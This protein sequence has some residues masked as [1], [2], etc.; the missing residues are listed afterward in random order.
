MIISA[1]RLLREAPACFIEQ[2]RGHAQ[3]S[4]GRLDVW[5]A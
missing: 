3:I 4:L 1:L 5:M 2:F